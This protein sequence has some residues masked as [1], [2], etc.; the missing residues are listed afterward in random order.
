[1]SST[2]RG[3]TRNNYDFYETPLWCVQ[4]L[5]AIDPFLPT[6]TLDP[7]AGNGALIRGVMNARN[8]MIEG[9]EIQPELIE[10]SRLD[11]TQGDGL[12]SDWSDE[13]IIMNPPYRDA[14]AWVDKALS[15]SASCTALLR[16]GFLSSKRRMSLWTKHPPN[17]IYILSKRPSFTSDGKTDSAD[18]MWVHWKSSETFG[19]C[20]VSSCRV[21]WIAP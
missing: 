2:N 13:H 3:R 21:R 7:C 9:I 5:F 19:L 11:I 8:R 20:L 17:G 14:E 15:E 10:Q 12:K 18:Y 1:M 4:K 6:P 16:L